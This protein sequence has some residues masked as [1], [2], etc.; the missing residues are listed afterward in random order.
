M[1]G[2]VSV[3][4]SGLSELQKKLQEEL[5]KDAK[6]ALRIALNAGGSDVKKAM[7]AIAP[8]EDGGENSG[9]LRDHINIKVKMS[10]GDLAGSAF[11]GPSTAVY[12]GKE[13]KEGQVNF[14]TAGGKRVSFFSKT[15]GKVTA[16]RVAR[17]LEFG[18]RHA[19]K[20]P[21]MTQAWES[22]KEAALRH[23]VEK[24]KS[25]LQLG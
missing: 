12:P 15:A 19:G 2:T 22:S 10:R 24:L 9:F 6:L 13:G 4:I 5:P 23:I 8:V 18:T 3:K 11:V 25:I 20:H 16:A 1:P 14:K 7:A 21:F 17:F